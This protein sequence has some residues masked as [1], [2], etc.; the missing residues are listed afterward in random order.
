MDCREI[1]IINMMINWQKIETVLLDMDGTI[2]DLHF[3][4]YFWQE[5][6]PIYWGQLNGLE[7]EAAKRELLPRF[8]AREGTL[9]WYCLD[10]WSAELELDVLDLKNNIEHLIQYRPSAEIF[11]EMLNQQGKMPIM[12][13]NAHEQLIN[14]KL[15]K[16][17]MGRYFRKIISS[18]G[19]GFPKEEQEFWQLLQQQVGFNPE[20]TLLIDDNLTVLRSAQ[21][22]GIAHL[23]SIAK[24]DSRG[25]ARQT[26]EFKVIECFTHVMPPVT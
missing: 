17:G 16:T 2:L 3:D 5:Y 4:N 10:F 23:Y 1:V 19:I 18:H 6:L 22:F 14:M 26:E 11:L 9:S 12:V 8:K 24:P 21:K 15:K 7:A 13:T 20:H 25:P